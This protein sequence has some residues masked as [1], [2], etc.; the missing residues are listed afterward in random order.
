METLAAADL[1]KDFL[2]PKIRDL[3]V[4]DSGWLEKYNNFKQRT[5]LRCFTQFC[6]LILLPCSLILCIS[7]P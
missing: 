5:F 1:Q 4:L 7:V 2:R 6:Y 3:T